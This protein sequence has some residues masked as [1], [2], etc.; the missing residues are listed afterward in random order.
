[1]SSTPRAKLRNLL[2]TV[3]LGNFMSQLDNSIVNVS[4]PVIQQDFH[5]SLT[6]TEWVVTT[7]LITI[8]S[9]MLLCGK[10]GDV[11]GRKRFFVTGLSLFTAGS[12]ICGF[13][14]N[15]T[16]LLLGRV[17]QAVGGAMI[18]S[19]GPAISTHAVEEKDRGK[20]L[21]V[22]A[23]S[24]A[25]ALCLGPLLGGMLTAAFGW[26][27]IFFVNVPVG[28]IAI[29]LADRNIEKDEPQKNKLFDWKGGTL[30]IL[31]LWLILLPLDTLGEPYMPTL[32]FVGLIAAG[33]LCCFLTVFYEWK[34][35]EPV[36]SLSL[37]RSRIFVYNSVAAMLNFTA[38]YVFV[39]LFPFYLETFRN[40]STA[41]AGLLYLPMPIAFLIAA[42]VS[43]ALSD[44]IGSRGLCITGM[45]VMSVALLLLSF[46]KQNTGL[47]Y[48]IFVVALMGIGYGM[49]QTPNNSAVLGDVPDAD[50]GAT[51][52]MLST[53]KNIGM[54]LGVTVSGSLFSA[55][56]TLGKQNATAQNLSAQ[57]IQNQSFTFSL[58]I[59]FLV[60][61]VIALLAMVACIPA[62]VRNARVAQGLEI[63]GNVT[64]LGS[65]KFSHVFLLKGSHNYLIDTGMPGQGEKI[66]N[67]LNKLGIPPISIEAIFLTH[68]DV[69]HTGNAQMLQEATNAKVYAP[70]EDVP[71]I[72]GEKQ[73]PGIKRFITFFTKP[74]KPTV[75]ESY[76]G[77]LLFGEILPVC[78]PG[79]TPGHTMLLFDRVLFCGDLLR[80]KGKLKQSA[81]FMNWDNEKNKDSLKLLDTLDFDW[82]CPAHSKPVKN[83]TAFKTELAKLADSKG[84]DMK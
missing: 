42:P 83:D 48:L 8:S 73:R 50:R 38:M 55:L 18:I 63:T 61:M 31:A 51:S 68:H 69:D 58:H 10:L 3:A 4:L 9:M 56:Q 60:A 19:T 75:T 49:F 11:F 13:S 24:I 41:Q 37:F 12:L 5:I 59:T 72:M 34:Q 2:I 78:A 43:G 22:T 54:I 46:L 47:P 52:G 20:A 21:S 30:F 1:M 67:E 6:L 64:M 32:L 65:S 28:V 17:I 74:I 35:A 33:V 45:G 84:T 82:I 62:K 26:H 25:V 7:Y 16:V 70:V 53:M 81:A 44:R 71:Y 36:L 29:I 77:E 76:T 66:L 40:L 23:I 14:G 80:Y 27:S 39:F 57:T 15:I 79:H